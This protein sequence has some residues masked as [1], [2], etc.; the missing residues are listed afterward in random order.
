MAMAS[1]SN[2]SEELKRV[3]VVLDTNSLIY[4]VEKPIDLQHHLSLVVP[5]C[6]DLLV[7]ASVINELKK[8]ASEG[9]PKERRL[10]SLAL[11]IAEKC[12]IVAEREASK[13]ADQVI[14]ERAKQE[15]W[16]VVTN[17][18]SLRRQLR[19]QGVPVIFIKDRILR[20]EGEVP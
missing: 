5:A 16:L 11:K 14:L 13:P 17:D 19:Q 3:K 12:H 2:L 7:P 18:R 9:K 15:K 8:M 6:F 20:I 1:L 10:A 4:S